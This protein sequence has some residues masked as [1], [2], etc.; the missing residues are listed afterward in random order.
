MML[1][2]LS[3]LFPGLVCLV[4]IL[5]SGC[6]LSE[7]QTPAAQAPSSVP[8]SS[9]GVTHEPNLTVGPD[10]T[11]YLSWIEEISDAD[12]HALKFSRLESGGWSNAKT[13]ASGDNWFVNWADVPSLFV[14]TESDMTAHWLEKNGASKYAYGV[15]ISRSTDGGSSWSDPAWLHED[16]SA[17]EHG[18]ATFART[19]DATVAAWL[20]GR[21]YGK[22]INEMTLIAREI[23]SDGSMSDEV[24]L[25]E[26]VCDCCPV[27]SASSDRGEIL[28]AYRNRTEDEIRD[29][30]TVYFDGQEWHDPRIVHDDGWHIAGCPVNGPA[31]SIKDDQAAVAWFTVANDSARVYLATGSVS[32]SEFSDP[33]RIDQGKPVGRVAVSH[34]P[35]GSTLVLWMENAEADGEALILARRV[36]KGQ[37]SEAVVVAETS[38]SR[39][40]G[41]PKMAY[42]GKEVVFAWTQ[43]SDTRKVVTKVM[44]PDLFR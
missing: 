37:A 15:R 5:A 31:V 18:F 30:S 14:A 21:K 34:L 10:S 8:G 40:S 27:S 12:S 35:D 28:V 26:L 33:N 2:K 9:E 44:S 43:T 22:G 41:F 32:G 6:Q 11:V 24:I 25:D 7:S 4:I 20:D 17:S 23:S 16:Q 19:D 39:G 13:I 38:S 3:A 1:H 42:T 29:I 36:N